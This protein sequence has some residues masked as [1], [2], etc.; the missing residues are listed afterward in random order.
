MTPEGEVRFSRWERGVN[1]QGVV[2][3]RKEDT[4][5]SWQYRFDA[6]S[7]PKGSMDEHVAIG[8]RYF[9]MDDTAFHLE[10]MP[11]GTTRLEIVAHYRVSS[12]INFYAV[13]A[14]DFL[15]RDFVS[16]ILALYKRRSETAQSAG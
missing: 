4:S 7:F 9:D 2:T 3:S 12:A 10:P 15:G 1:F 16:T 13:P 6:H 5:I 14:A 11:G 8:G